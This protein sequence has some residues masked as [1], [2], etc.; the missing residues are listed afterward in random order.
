MVQGRPPLPLRY[1]RKFWHAKNL[2]MP[3]KLPKVCPHFTLKTEYGYTVT[4]LFFWLPSPE[5]AEYDNSGN[6]NSIVE[7][8]IVIQDCNTR[9]NSL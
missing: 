6:I 1:Y 7:H 5:M 4:L 3:T 9:K 8:N 2:S